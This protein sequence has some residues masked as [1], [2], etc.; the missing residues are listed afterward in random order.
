VTCVHVGVFPP[1]HKWAKNLQNCQAKK[2]PRLIQVLRLEQNSRN[3]VYE[4]ICMVYAWMHACVHAAMHAQCCISYKQEENR[5]ENEFF[6][7]LKT[8]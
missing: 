5:S 2:R 7:F 6:K 4:C 8:S 1:T 3:T